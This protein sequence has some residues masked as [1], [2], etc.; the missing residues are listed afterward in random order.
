VL[1]PPF[2]GQHRL[3]CPDLITDNTGR[4]HVCYIKKMAIVILF[5]TIFCNS[6][7]LGKHNVIY[8]GNGNT[9]GSVPT[10]QTLYNFLGAVT[11]LDNTGNLIRTNYTFAGWSKVVHIK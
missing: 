9:S 1:S 10:D 2:P 6:C 5:T 3:S 7:D 4:N 11:V 8:D